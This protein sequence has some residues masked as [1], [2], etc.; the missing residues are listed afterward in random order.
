MQQPTNRNGRSPH[1]LEG[2]AGE[3][4]MSLMLI[5]RSFGNRASLNESLATGGPLPALAQGL[6][7]AQPS[8]IAAARAYDL[9][10]GLH[11][12]RVD[13]HGAGSVRGVKAWCTAPGSPDRMVTIQDERAAMWLRR[14]FDAKGLQVRLQWVN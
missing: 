1:Q 7:G 13:A 4:L 12:I 5:H 11:I 9:I 6:H 8:L 14:H 3:P 10:V 2:G